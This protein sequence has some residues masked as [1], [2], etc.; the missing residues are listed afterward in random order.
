MRDD[1]GNVNIGL[2]RVPWSGLELLLGV[3]L[4]WFL[5]PAAAYAAVTGLNVKHWYYGGS[6]PELDKRLDLWVHTL[7]W[8]FQVLTFPLLFAALSDTRLDQLGLTTR[9]LGRNIL[10]GV[11]G[12][13]ALTPPV[14]GV[15]WLVSHLYF[16]AG[17]KGV[18][19]HALEV[20]AQQ[21]LFP[22]EWGMLIFTAMVAAPF[23]EELS[24]RGVLQP[25]LASRRWGSH[26]TMLGALVLTV[27]YRGNDL[28]DA[29]PK[30]INALATA[31]TPALFVLA[32]L[33]IYLLVCWSD[34]TSAGVPA[35]M[36]APSTAR[37]FSR[38]QSIILPPS[39]GER[40]TVGVGQAPSP[41]GEEGEQQRFG[42]PWP[43]IFAASLLFACV[44]TSV[45]PTPVP[46]FVLAIGLGVLAHRTRSLVGPIV[47]HGLFNA[48]SCVKLLMGW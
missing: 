31:A 46:L 2:R 17:Q 32:L 29:W 39:R 27:V 14:F 24:F 35:P 9:R 22:V 28:L 34:R 19:K 26:V 38:V 1:S 3:Y 44:H 5:W 8:P 41:T 18:E 47:L 48:V 33:P 7:A 42:Y 6:V 20:M 4:V 23:L 11:V 16:W 15:Y 12:M 30:G 25:W 36:S 40:V 21:H 43:A 37:W 45:W 10:A 13:L